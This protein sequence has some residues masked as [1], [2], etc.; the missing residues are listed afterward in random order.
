MTDYTPI[1]C[2]LHSEYELA[3]MHREVLRLRWQDE[4][5]QVHT[6]SVTPLDLVT[7]D[8]AEFL[9]ALG[10]D[11]VTHQIRLDRIQRLPCGSS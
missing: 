4:H 3:I 2:G 1:E 5:L 10:R 11:G 8:G 7:R 9:L 6:E